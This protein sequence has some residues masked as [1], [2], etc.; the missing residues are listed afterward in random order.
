MSAWIASFTKWFLAASTGM[1]I[2]VISAVAVASTGVI[3][4]PVTIANNSQV[5]T[6]EATQ[7]G[8]KANAAGTGQK[9][10][11]P[12]ASPTPTALS[13]TGNSSSP[14]PSPSTSKSTTKT[15]ARVPG[16]PTNARFNQGGCGPGY[17][18]AAITVNAPSD[19]GS[20]AITGYEVGY[21]TD[22]GSSFTWVSFG[23]TPN[24][25]MVDPMPASATYD[26]VVRALNAAGPSATS[27]MFRLPLSVQMTPSAPTGVSL[28]GRG[29]GS[30][31][32]GI[33]ISCGGDIIYT[34]PQNTGVGSFTYMTGYS[35]DGGNTWSFSPA[36]IGQQDP[37]N[38]SFETSTF[39][40]GQVG[41]LFVGVKIVNSYGESPLVS[42]HFQ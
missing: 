2:T 35:W 37:A 14:S 20:S 18:G 34:P 10:S 31:D 24:Y 1:K 15:T 13:T 38:L 42:L 8:N 30:G 25:M 39:P 4:I 21:S 17:C 16:A 9:S 33:T 27:A 26:I 5:L 7:N 36:G 6:V 22:G 19:S 23:N 40:I 41:N 28:G 11:T 32:N 29:C 12:T 3:A